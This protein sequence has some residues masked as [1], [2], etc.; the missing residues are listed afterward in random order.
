MVSGLPKFCSQSLFLVVTNRNR[1][2][3]RKYDVWNMVEKMWNQKRWKVEV[4]AAPLRPP[5][6]Q[7]LFVGNIFGPM[8]LV[9]S[10]CLQYLPNLVLLTLKQCLFY[11]W[12]KFD[13]LMFKELFF[14]RIDCINKWEWHGMAINSTEST[15]QEVIF[16][17]MTWPSNQCPTVAATY[18]RRWWGPNRLFNDKLGSEASREL[19]RPAF[20]C[21]SSSRL[22][23]WSGWPLRDQTW[24]TLRNTIHNIWLV[25]Y[26]FLFTS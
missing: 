11:L 3:M 25:S 18:F 8:H 9:T 7:S 20:T 6:L 1:G 10:S 5:H 12:S 19:S 26:G 2:S 17:L 24:K 21:F 4:L 14:I 22:W 15:N 13:E 16:N 23:P